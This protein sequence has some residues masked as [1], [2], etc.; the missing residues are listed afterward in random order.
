MAWATGRGH[1]PVAARAGRSARILLSPAL[2]RNVGPWAL[3]SAAGE[4]AAALGV[5][6]GVVE[7][8]VV[9][10]RGLVRLRELFAAELDVRRSLYLLSADRHA[11]LV[12]ADR[13]PSERHEGEMAP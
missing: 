10:E 4:S 7:L 11:K 13:D 1:R 5:R 12:G 8:E 9:V 2:L 3:A 6:R